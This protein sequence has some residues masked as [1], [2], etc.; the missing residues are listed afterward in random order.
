MTNE[1]LINDKKYHTCGRCRYDCIPYDKY[2]CTACIGSPPRRPALLKLESQS[3][4]EINGSI[5]K[6][7]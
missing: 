7:E 6:E 5:Y 3:E 1:E 2:P 4:Q